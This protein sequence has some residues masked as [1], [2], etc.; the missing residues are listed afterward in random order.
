[1][2]EHGRKR[3]VLSPEEQQALIDSDYEL[4]SDVARRDK[5][6]LDE[7]YK[8]YHR[9]ARHFG[10]RAYEASGVAGNVVDPDDLSQEAM[11]YMLRRAHN[12][13][14]DAEHPFI[15][16]AATYTPLVLLAHARAERQIHIPENIYNMLNEIRRINQ[17][18]MSEGKRRMSDEEI[19]AMFHIPQNAEE[20]RVSV[21]A[22][23]TAEKLT[24]Y[25]GSLDTGFSP[26]TDTLPGESYGYDGRIGLES[27]TTGVE[28]TTEESVEKI[29]LREAL[30]KVL[31][32][33]SEREENMVRMR[34][35][36]GEDG[37]VYTI[38]EIAKQHG[39]SSQRTIQII[40]KAM[41][42]LQHSSRS[43]YLK[44]F[45]DGHV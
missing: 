30:D 23:R 19:A 35:G 40:K 15:V 36:L 43:E 20:S 8:R 5:T 14:P 25:M 41:S 33:L 44:P 12:Y 16:H 32:T 42:K 6:A 10:R 1:M 31:G 11:E 37:K 2:N 26:N 4:C 28:P 13:S 22:L 24:S 18:R 38:I 27:L 17:A 39:L 45:L 7:F 29:M 21:R 3:K 34:Y 9:L